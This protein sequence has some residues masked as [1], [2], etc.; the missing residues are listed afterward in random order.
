LLPFAV[1]RALLFVVNLIFEGKIK[2]MKKILLILLVFSLT[3]GLFSCKGE[4]QTILET[5]ETTTEPAVETGLSFLDYAVVRTAD[6]GEAGVEKTAA[7]YDK[8]S[9]L[10]GNFND[11]YTDKDRSAKSDVKEILIGATNRPESEE[12]SKQLA[13][14]EYAIAVVGNKLVI[15]GSNNSL[16]L[17]AIDYF[18]NTYL[19]EGADGTV[20][21]DLFYKAKSET[22]VIA[23]KGK[24]AFKLVRPDNADEKLVALFI[25][26]QNDINDKTGVRLELLTDKDYDETN[27][28][29]EILFGDVECAQTDIVKAHTAPGEFS[30]DF[31][32]K[33]VVIYSGSIEGMAAA[34]DAFVE[35]M[36]TSMTVK[37]GEV[38][39]YLNKS[40]V[41]NTIN[42]GLSYYNDVPLEANGTYYDSVYVSG[43][44][45]L[46]LCW[47]NAS[48]GMLLDYASDLE[49]DG[50]TKHQELNNDSIHAIT[51]YKDNAE[52]H[53]YLMKRIKIFR[54]C[55]EDN[56]ILPQNAYSYKKVCDVAVTQIAIEHTIDVYIGMSYLIR[57]E[58][59]TF[60]V[61]DG[62][63]G[64]AYNRD[65]LYDI[66]VEQ[67]PN[68]VEDVVVTAWIVTHGD[69]DHYGTLSN[70]HK[71]KHADDITI[72]SLLGSDISPRI[73]ERTSKARGFTFTQLNGQYGG[74]KY[75]KIHT[76]QQLSY[77]G[78][79]ITIMQTHE[80]VFSPGS[81]SSISTTFNDTSTV[82]DVVVKGEAVDNPV[83]DGY[84]RF[85][86]LGD[87]QGNAA[88]ILA[89]NYTS[90]LK[91]DV[92]QLA[93]HGIGGGSTDCYMA[94][95]PEI[96]MWP[97]GRTVLE[98][99]G[100]NDGVYGDGSRY[101]ETAKK[102][103]VDKGVTFIY[104]AKADYTFWFGNTVTAGYTRLS[105]TY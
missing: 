87:I 3:L 24:S 28:T 26:L 6:V 34:E 94:I 31:V 93:H 41:S 36:E 72:K 21:Q 9:K 56:A 11:F 63:S 4:E 20:P 69:G 18:V 78:I 29:Y 70:F 37:D 79:T 66:M 71:S 16:L 12:I 61:I 65:V 62:G 33:K 82:F 38:S 77:P 54:V 47:N 39:I 98:T 13:G 100:K 96:V 67:L 75:D 14:D 60:V 92:M 55:T 99:G 89:A 32:G 19:C 90:D 27:D 58:D 2:V 68:G 10:S 84:T 45:G 64:S 46:M 83:K 59:G 81:H 95:A 1:G 57:L 35:L 76:G 7:L 44:S 86:F 85:M 22:V 102:Y 91:S 15:V 104:S 43:D 53:I 50:F 52:V 40:L 97:A 17:V 74:C 25:E 49:G 8:L 80:D 23:D 30:I 73:I 103:L 105:D 88:N 48:E 101:K 51:F 5:D 42:D